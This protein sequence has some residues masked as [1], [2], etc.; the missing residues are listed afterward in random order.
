MSNFINIS[1]QELSNSGVN[2][3]QVAQDDFAHLGKKSSDA[4][5]SH[6]KQLLTSKKFQVV[7]LARNNANPAQYKYKNRSRIQQTFKF[8][9]GKNFKENIL[10][11]TMRDFAKPLS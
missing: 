8:S 10:F 4:C 7:I 5:H 2:A 9:F 11:L 3:V 1:P 6:V